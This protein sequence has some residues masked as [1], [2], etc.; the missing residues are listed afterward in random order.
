MSSVGVSRTHYPPAS[1]SVD[2]Q[3]DTK[4]SAARERLERVE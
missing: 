4:A 3:S 2:K 1:A